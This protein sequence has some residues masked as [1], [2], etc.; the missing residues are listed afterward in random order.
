[1]K[2]IRFNVE[3]LRE[4]LIHFHR[5]TGV[6]FVFFDADFH[7]IAAYPEES[8]AFCA[9]I[10]ST[11]ART[12]CREGDKIAC[13][14]C[15]K[16]GSLYSYRC[17]AG[18]TEVTAPVRLGDSVIGYIMF[19]QI[20]AEDKDRSR[21]LAYAKKYMDT[22]LAESAVNALIS[23]SES[24]IDSA[25]YILSMCACYLCMSDIFRTDRESFT[26]HLSS[27]IH[28]HIT[29]ELSVEELC[30]VFG[31]S[32]YRLYELARQHFGMPIASYIRKKKV[33]LSA[34]HLV[35][36]GATVSEAA[37]AAGFSDYNYFSKI[38]KREMGLLPTEYKKKH[39]TQKG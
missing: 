27:Y 32:R 33:E 7:R 28:A 12:L 10:K 36:R 1:M 24:E 8:C 38:F 2:S 3:K 35:T 23:K 25:A 16:S 34:H 15:K 29:E 11:E 37:E 39:N 31:I 30:A 26:D 20:A 6:R 9:A 19:G 14:N 4:I 13:E 22:S 18:L 17:H 5:L 21:I